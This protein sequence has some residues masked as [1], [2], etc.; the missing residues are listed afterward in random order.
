MPRKQYKYHY[1][2]KTI[3]TITERYYIGMHSTDNIDDGYMGSGKILRYSINKYGLEN[4]NRQI[5][6]FL[7]NRKSLANREKEIIDNLWKDDPQCMNLK[8]GGYGGSSKETQF[9]RS[10]SGGLST[11]R[12]NPD[13]MRLVSS[14][15]GISSF[16]RKT[17]IHNPNTKHFHGKKHSEKTKDRI[18]IANS[19]SQSGE[20]NSQFGTIWI[21]DGINTKKIKKDQNVPDGFRIGRTLKKNNQ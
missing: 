13:K 15:G 5:L 14:K 18:S 10:K 12:K 19:I 3:C 21:T 4:H 11:W 9:L 17:G 2:Y 6:E 8:E 16:I 1:I 20:R 7:D